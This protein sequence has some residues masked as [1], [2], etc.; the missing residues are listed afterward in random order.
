MKQIYSAAAIMYFCRPS[1]WFHRQKPNRIIAEN[2][3]KSLI[4]THLAHAN[5]HKW[6]NFEASAEYNRTPQSHDVNN[7]TIEFR[8]LIKNIFNESLS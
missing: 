8:Q 2:T 4:V 1:T 6:T 5:L 7:T 3:N